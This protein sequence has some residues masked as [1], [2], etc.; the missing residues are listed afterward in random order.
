[1]SEAGRRRWWAAAAVV[2]MSGA[3]AAGAWVGFIR[4][5]SAVPQPARRIV[6]D[7]AGTTP[8]SS[9]AAE[10]PGPS[11]PAPTALPPIPPVPDAGA[12]PIV[13]AGAI[14]A[15]GPAEPITPRP[16]DTSVLTNGVAPPPVPPLPRAESPA[17]PP[18]P[19][20]PEV[21][22]VLPPPASLGPPPTTPPVA[23]V[24]PAPTPLPPASPTP[25]AI[26]PVAPLIPP[27]ETGGLPK[28][29]E[30]PQVPTRGTPDSGLPKAN[31][32]NTVKPDHVGGGSGPTVP[33]AP[34]LPV[35]DPVR[36]VLPT[37]PPVAPVVPTV[38]HP[39][40]APGKTVDRPRPNEGPLPKDRDL[41]PIPNPTTPLHPAPTPGDTLM[42]TVNL[43]AAAAVLGGV[44]SA[45]ATP[46]AAVPPVAPVVPLPGMIAAQDK[47]ELEAVNKKLD[48]IQAQLKQLNEL[49]NGRRDDKGVRIESDPGVVEE[50]K[51]LKDKLAK[52]D[53]EVTKMKSQTS[54]RPVTPADPRAGKG[55]VRIVNEY[56]VQISIVVNGTSYRVA[57]T[58]T[59]DIEVPAGEFT[60]QLLE[61]GAAPTKSVIKE[62]ETVTLRIK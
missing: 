40:E 45:P 47:T 26:P 37:P 15:P 28:S 43:T 38:G 61:A 27:P 41:F 8:R 17:L 9:Q 36:P 58:R 20:P 30:L 4:P 33:V 23:P 21:R 49:L 48:S 57:P 29:P 6:T 25:P 53:E 59:Q 22:P 62:K 52:L 16:L 32:E 7:E 34:V 12:S 35:P 19:K 55:T 18:V 39:G 46:V 2:V 10:T 11:V 24:L 14:A 5:V 44:L 56:P 42:T 3:M 31:S 54:L 51:R 50:L 1:M 60:Y 13:P